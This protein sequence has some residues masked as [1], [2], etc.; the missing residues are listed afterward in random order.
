MGIELIVA[1]DLSGGQV[2]RVSQGRLDDM[3]VYDDDPVA[4]ALRWEDSGATRLHVVDLDGAVAGE[5]RHREDV[6]RVIGATSI[7]V[8]VGGGVRTLDALRGWVDWGADRVVV[9]TAALTDPIFLGE[10]LDAYGDRLV[11]ALDA[12]DGELRLSGWTKASGLDLVGTAA[13]LAM[14]GVRRLLVTD[15]ARDGMLAGPNVPMLA[16]VAEAAGVPV[17]A[18]GG[19]SSA[20][21][22]RALAALGPRGVEAAI[23]GRA[24]Y[25]GTLELRDALAAAGG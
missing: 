20:D 22:V 11:V 14:D 6:A 24:L 17:I 2:V 19:V 12:R 23:V 9:G 10:A 7:P 15:I 8:Q 4:C 13:K 18:A 21:D 5:P 25:A 3:T 1:I 16:A